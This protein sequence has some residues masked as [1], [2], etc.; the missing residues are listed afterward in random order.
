MEK[1]LPLSVVVATTSP[2]PK[3]RATLDSLWGQA[4][5]AGGEILVVDGHGQGVP[6]DLT[7][8]YPGTVYLR[9][10]EASVF[11]LRALGMQHARGEIVAITEDHCLVCPDWCRQMLETHRRY[12]DAAAVGG[13]VD[14]GSTESLIDW[15]NYF[16]AHS[17]MMAPIPGGRAR[18]ISA[19]AGMALKRRVVPKEIPPHGIMEGLFLVELHRRG[20]VLI[21]N[22]QI[23]VHHVQ[24]HGFW[25]TFAIHFHN[26]R[27]I[28]GF[29]KRTMNPWHVPLR[30]SWCLALPGILLLR[31]I[32]VVMSKGRFRRQLALS[33]P[34]VAALACC[35]AAG[36]FV[37]YLAGAGNSPEKLS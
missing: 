37:G 3:V 2:W 11:V 18:T 27:S 36:E 32:V 15:A 7:A 25:N 31:P 12:P 35:H 1:R 23:V 17:P 4:R 20:E 14:N 5:A 22:D 28:G 24:S 16:V 33:L 8:H 29:R 21:A 19:Q 30:L 26:G 9:K 34:L 13:A 10:P 6:D